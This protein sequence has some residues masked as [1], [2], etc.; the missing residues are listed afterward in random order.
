M[1]SSRFVKFLFSG[2]SL[3][4]LLLTPAPA[5]SESLVPLRVETSPSGAAV[6]VD[7]QMRGETPVTL[8][9]PEGKH[10][11]FVYKKGMLPVEQEITLTPG[12]RP[13]V[14]FPLREQSGGLVV[15]SDPPGARVGFDGRMLGRTPLAFERLPMGKHE[16]TIRKEGFDEFR[17]VIEVDDQVPN[18]VGVRLQGPPV[19]VFVVADQ[20]SRV[21][22]DGSY[23]G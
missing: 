7:G 4:C 13:S 19:S 18:E 2:A 12:D 5:A 16:L 22:V 10:A 11:L 14:K 17:D 21:Y 20:G 6:Y 9:L 3:C 1:Q 8:Q 15:L 23:A